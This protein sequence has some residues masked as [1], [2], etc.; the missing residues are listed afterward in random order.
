MIKW[1]SEFELPQSDIFNR[2]ANRNLPQQYCFHRS[3]CIG[4]VVGGCQHQLV[5]HLAERVCKSIYCQMGMSLHPV[6]WTKKANKFANAYRKS[7]PIRKMS[8]YLPD[9]NICSFVAA[10]LL[11]I[12]WEVCLFPLLCRPNRGSDTHNAIRLGILDRLALLCCQNSS[13][14]ATFECTAN[15]KCGYNSAISQSDVHCVSFFP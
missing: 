1:C 5:L 13:L 15:R 9:W 2:K 3:H 10:A 7:L 12:R 4:G 14:G 6:K 11:C 8:H